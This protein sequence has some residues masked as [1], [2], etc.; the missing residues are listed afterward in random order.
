[1]DHT[2]EALFSQL[3]FRF[4]I[5]RELIGW[6][7]FGIEVNR[8]IPLYKSYVHII[9]LLLYCNRWIISWPYLWSSLFTSL[10]DWGHKRAFNVRVLIALKDPCLVFSRIT[11][12]LYLTREIREYFLVFSFVYFD[13]SSVSGVNPGRGRGRGGYGGIHTPLKLLAMLPK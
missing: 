4:R 12:Q 7:L 3:H 13:F 5:F 10:R 2:V 8:F 6:H 11:V 9:I 1:M